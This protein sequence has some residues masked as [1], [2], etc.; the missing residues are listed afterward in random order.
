MSKRRPSVFISCLRRLRSA[1]L[2]LVR[3][4]CKLHQQTFQTVERRFDI[5]VAGLHRA[6]PDQAVA[7]QQFSGLAAQR[8]SREIVALRVIELDQQALRTIEVVPKNNDHHPLAGL[9]VN[10]HGYRWGLL[11][12]PPAPG[13]EGHGNQ[14]YA[15]GCPTEGPVISDP[16]A[17]GL[18]VYREERREWIARPVRRN[19]RCAPAAWVRLLRRGLAATPRTAWRTTGQAFR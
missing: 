2:R 13:N 16:T 4:V 18:F 6:L 7:G 12:L 10:R 14:Q 9:R 5:E 15:G 19:P 11:A 1:S 17:F 8:Q 3:L